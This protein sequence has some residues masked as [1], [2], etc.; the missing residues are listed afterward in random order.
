VILSGGQKQRLV[1]SPSREVGC[2]ELTFPFR[3]LPGQ[4]MH[5]NLL[6]S[7]TMCSVALTVLPSNSFSPESLAETA[8]LGKRILL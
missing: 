7:S 1:Q 3:L 8:F 6:Q 5:G 4:S 2:I